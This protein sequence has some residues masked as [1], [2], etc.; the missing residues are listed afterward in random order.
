MFCNKS[1]KMARSKWS[2][3]WSTN[4]NEK[5]KIMGGGKMIGQ[6]MEVFLRRVDR[7]RIHAFIINKLKRIHV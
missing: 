1:S 2:G 5:K 7:T 3:D 6:Q 4:F